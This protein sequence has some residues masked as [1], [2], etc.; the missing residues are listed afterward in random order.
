MAATWPIAGAPRTIISRIANDTSP[1]ERHGY[2]TSAS[3]SL[4]WSIR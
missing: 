3:G 1:A 2:S 4:R